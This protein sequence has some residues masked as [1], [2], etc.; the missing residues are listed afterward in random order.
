MV[1]RP[2]CGPSPSVSVNI[3]L[4]PWQSIFIMIIMTIIKIIIIIICTITVFQIKQNALSHH[5]ASVDLCSSLLRLLRMKIPMMMPMVMM[6]M[7]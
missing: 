3:N 2:I 6:T 7:A 5:M 1:V 4:V